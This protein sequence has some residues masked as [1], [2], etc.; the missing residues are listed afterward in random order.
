MLNLNVRTRVYLAAGPTDLRKGFGG[1]Y[2]AVKQ[3]LN[4]ESSQW[5]LFRIL[6][7]EPDWNKSVSVGWQRA[8]GLRKAF[9]EGA[10]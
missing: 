5:A 3:K 4:A 6:Q 2:A 10:L 7:S 8:V 9:R 1:L